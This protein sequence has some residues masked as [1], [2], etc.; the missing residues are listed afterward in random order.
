LREERQQNRGIRKGKYIER[1][2]GKIL[3]SRKKER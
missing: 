3:E 1:R 2:K